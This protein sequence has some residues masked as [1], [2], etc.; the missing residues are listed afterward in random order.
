MSTRIRLPFDTRPRCFKGSYGKIVIDIG[1]RGADTDGIVN[2][3][4]DI[5]VSNFVAGAEQVRIVRKGAVGNVA[6]GTGTV[7]SKAVDWV[8]DGGTAEFAGV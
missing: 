6:C 5:V 7:A 3:S 2:A 8:E 4:V 1:L